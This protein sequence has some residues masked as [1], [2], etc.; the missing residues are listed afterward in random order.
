MKLL[1][2]KKRSPELIIW[3]IM[4]NR[5]KDENDVFEPS[6]NSTQPSYISS[7]FLCLTELDQPQK[8]QS[9]LWHRKCGCFL[10]LHILLF[11]DE[12]NLLKNY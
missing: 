8:F 12:K 11:Y 7:N 6:E 2:L 5:H 9:L 4:C 10:E 3:N 1:K